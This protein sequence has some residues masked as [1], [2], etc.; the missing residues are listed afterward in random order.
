MFNRILAP[1]DGAA[2]SECVLPHLISLSRVFNAQVTL[3]QV[4]DCPTGTSTK[5][6][7]PLDWE[8]KKA[9]AESYLDNISAQLKKSG[10]DKVTTALLEG[11]PAQR[12]IEYIQSE[13]FDLV[14]LSSHGGTGLSQWNVSSV[15]RKVV[16]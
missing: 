3:V 14:V 1:L 16:Q 2:L 9:E 4:L 11:Q 15:V 8:I 5:P 13:D 10:L 7:D 12:L 6:V